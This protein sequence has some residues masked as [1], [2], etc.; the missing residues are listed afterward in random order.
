MNWNNCIM[1][2]LTSSYNAFEVQEPLWRRTI[3]GRQ[4]YCKRVF[5][6][7][8]I[9]EVVKWKR[10]FWG[11]VADFSSLVKALS[12]HLSCLAKGE[13]GQAFMLFC[14]ER[15]IMQVDIVEEWLSDISLLSPMVQKGDYCMVIHFDPEVTLVA[16]QKQAIRAL[17]DWWKKEGVP[18]V[19]TTILSSNLLGSAILMS[20]GFDLVE[21]TLP[22]EEVELYVFPSLPEK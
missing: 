1:L 18:R 8:D 7:S 2:A 22:D 16:L 21:Q 10:A 13:E 19:W 11:P 14:D 4:F 9:S 12:E 15:P 20:S 6:P 17:C 5:I 3:E